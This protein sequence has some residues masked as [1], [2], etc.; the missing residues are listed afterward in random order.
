MR[1]APDTPARRADWGEIDP[2]ATLVDA[3]SERSRTRVRFPAPPLGEFS[4]QFA[5]GLKLPAPVGSREGI[6]RGAPL[7]WTSNA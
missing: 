2:R 4:V 1:L 6:D 7:A 5:K 3:V